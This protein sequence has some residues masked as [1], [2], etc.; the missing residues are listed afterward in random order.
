[1]HKLIINSLLIVHVVNFYNGKYFLKN[2]IETNVEFNVKSFTDAC[3]SMHL[4]G[5][6]LHPV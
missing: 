6:G 1:M 5:G 3:P 4:V 2:L